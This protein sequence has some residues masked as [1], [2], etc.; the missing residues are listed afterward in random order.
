[1]IHAS[2]SSVSYRFSA[3]DIS[4]MDKKVSKPNKLMSAAF[5]RD[6]K[7]IRALLAKKADVNARNMNRGDSYF[8]GHAWRMNWTPLHYACRYRF[9]P[10]FN[11]LPYCA[12][13]R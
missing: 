9:N 6:T 11:S 4:P 8:T 12:T 5:R 1:M 7:A 2:L 10:S 13:N 3:K